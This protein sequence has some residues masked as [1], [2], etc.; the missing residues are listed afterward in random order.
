MAKEITYSYGKYRLKVDYKD[1]EKD[2]AQ[3]S[4]SDVSLHDFPLLWSTS[5]NLQ[6]ANGAIELFKQ[7]GFFDVPIGVNLNRDRILSFYED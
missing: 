1:S 3:V 5:M 4:M 2:I 7:T 6:Q